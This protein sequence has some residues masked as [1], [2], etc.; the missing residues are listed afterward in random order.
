MFNS[1]G[2]IEPVKPNSHQTI[3]PTD[4]QRQL[5]IKKLVV[6]GRFFF[7]KSVGV[8]QKSVGTIF[9]FLNRPIFSPIFTNDYYQACLIK[10]VG[11]NAFS[12]FFF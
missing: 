12:L 2:T 3:F 5:K 4:F 7:K 1:V 6:V 11:T 8:T 10:S 9:I